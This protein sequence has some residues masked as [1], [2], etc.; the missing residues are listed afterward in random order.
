MKWIS[1]I[2]E[3]DKERNWWKES[4]N[5][6][7]GGSLYK[8]LREF[9]L[10]RNHLIPNWQEQAECLRLIVAYCEHRP[11]AYIFYQSY[12]EECRKRDIVAI[13]PADPP[14]L[15][16]YKQYIQEAKIDLE[17]S[18]LSG[19]P[20]AIHASAKA[21]RQMQFECGDAVGGLET[22][23]IAPCDAFEG[24]LDVL[25]PTEDV[26]LEVLASDKISQINERNGPINLSEL[27]C[28]GV[29]WGENS[30]PP[31]GLVHFRRHFCNQDG[32]APPPNV[33]R[34]RLQEVPWLNEEDILL[35]KIMMIVLYSYPIDLCCVAMSRTLKKH[36]EY[37]VP[38]DKYVR[39]G[40][41][42]LLACLFE[43]KSH[44]LCLHPL[45]GRARLKET[46]GK[47]TDRLQ[48][49]AIEPYLVVN[50]G[51]LAKK[52]IQ[53]TSN[54]GW[55]NLMRSDQI[56]PDKALSAISSHF[57]VFKDSKYIERARDSIVIYKGWPSIYK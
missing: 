29:L 51:H 55:D 17:Y 30:H 52:P 24:I 5:G 19:V 48:G 49:E 46:L 27:L 3:T 1:E 40:D 28:Y 50:L 8:V 43:R 7:L 15:Q 9:A 18:V 39:K 33:A 42:R 47:L 13:R 10:L 35:L 57:E 25:L 26:Q 14:T 21:L 2:I 4:I 44:I 53:F 11:H 34:E 23:T 32:L 45:I 41:G 31:L 54:S 37:M 6:I 22:S 56:G 36:P 16:S 38:V 20:V 12:L